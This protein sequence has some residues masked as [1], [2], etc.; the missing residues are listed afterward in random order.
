[1][2]GARWIRRRR[3]QLV[4]P[5]LLAGALLLLSGAGLPRSAAGQEVYRDGPR[6]LSLSLWGQS[7]YQFVE[8]GGGDAAPGE[9][10]ADLH[11]FMLRRLYLSV[12]GTVTPSLGFFV[13]LAGDRLG[14]QGLSNPGLGL[15]SGLAVRDAWVSL[16]LAGEAAQLQVG[17][18][19]I[20]FTRNY[21]T[22]STKA[23]LA[24]DL[25]WVQG[26][27]RGGIFYP[28]TV[29]RDEGATLWGNLAGGLLQYR[30][31]VADGEDSPA[32]NP[33]GHLRTAGR[34]SL[35]LFEPET[36]WFNEG[37]SLG[38]RRVLS[39][40]AG[41]DR[42]RLRFQEGDQDYLAWTLDLHLD[43]P[44]GGGAVTVDGSYLR[45]D[46]A[47]NGVGL[48][49]LTPGA[50]AGVLSLQAGYL[51]PGPAGP[52][53]LQPFARMERIGVEGGAPDTSIGGVGFNLFL[54]G[55]GNKLTVEA[56]F[57]SQEGGGG[58]PPP[59]EPFLLTAQIAFGL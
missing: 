44:V 20:P 54:A 12:R 24:A 56:T 6:S 27:Y 14:Q 21:G 39:L 31:M 2:D 58:S 55:H 23:L 38:T 25:D 33:G 42:Q 8:E 22:T 13:H 40:G 10:P 35:S 47:P 26:G 49:A 34:L 3:G 52:G 9:N 43:Q 15:G 19:Y 57:V 28:S 46:N 45:I 37:S 7:W 4:N 17:R 1:M 36:G 59:G 50:D 5:G 11:D 41:V 30:L 32:R 48:T 18:M 53:R 16:R 51:L 29:G